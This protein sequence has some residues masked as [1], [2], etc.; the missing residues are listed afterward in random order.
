MSA[1]RFR[2]IDWRGNRTV[3]VANGY[4]KVLLQQTCNRL[5]L[6]FF[7][8]AEGVEF[9]CLQRTE[10]PDTLSFLCT[11]ATFDRYCN[12]STVTFAHVRMYM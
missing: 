7:G 5:L 3:S 8:G 11:A 2:G 6:Y 1:G 9:P 12:M 4:N 10:V